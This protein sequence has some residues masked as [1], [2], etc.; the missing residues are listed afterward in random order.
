MLML[1]LS[2]T[3]RVRCPNPNRGFLMLPEEQTKAEQGLKAVPSHPASD[4]AT[5]LIKLYLPNDKSTGSV[6]A[7]LGAGKSLFSDSHT[8]A[9]PRSPKQWTI[10]R[11]FNQ[12]RHP[13][14]KKEE[15]S[16]GPNKPDVEYG[17][18]HWNYG[19]CWEGSTKKN[20]YC[21]TETLVLF[22]D[23]SQPLITTVIRNL[24][25]RPSPCYWTNTKWNFFKKLKYIL[26]N[27]WK[28]D[29]SI[30]YTL[31]THYSWS[32]L[33]TLWLHDTVQFSSRARGWM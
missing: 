17:E 15:K 19:F 24:T 18:T 30:N 16:S 14:Q 26:T 27:I 33:P 12:W 7:V 20:M 1:F 29:R 32:I 22:S 28:V 31:I 25:P 4:R 3:W 10:K 9:I 6:Q 13:A 21:F 11:E 8:K 5:I 23:R 2:T